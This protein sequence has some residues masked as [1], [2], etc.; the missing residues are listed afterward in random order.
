MSINTA[1]DASSFKYRSMNYLNKEMVKRVAMK[2]YLENMGEDMKLLIEKSMKFLLSWEDYS[3][4]E[5]D[6]I[7][8]YVKHVLYSIA[9]I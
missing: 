8:R 4:E 3:E 1:V 9:S 6:L 5:K 2:T 7:Q